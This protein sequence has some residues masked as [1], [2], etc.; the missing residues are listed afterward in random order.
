M[1]LSEVVSGHRT[2]YGKFCMIE[3]TSQYFNGNLGNSNMD[4][5]GELKFSN[6]TNEGERTNDLAR[7]FRLLSC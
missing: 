6:F 7:D 3:A 4:R 1:E 2:S 5:V